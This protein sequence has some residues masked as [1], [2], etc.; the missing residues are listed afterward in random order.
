MTH[1][2]AIVVDRDFGH[3]LVDLS[4]KMHVWVCD[5]LQN[6][7]SAEPIRAMSTGQSIE[8][9][10]TTFKVADNDSPKAMLL[11][12]LDMVDLHHGV[13]S[14]DP[15]WGELH[16]YGTTAT[17]ILRA[18]LTRFGARIIDQSQDGFRCAR[19]V[20]GAA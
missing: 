15:P 8:C 7:K 20:T 18:A 9:G 4:Q 5:S 14:H 12:V 19:E 2:V 16:I 6:R 11:G 17:P 10:V 1:T 3:P 13:Y